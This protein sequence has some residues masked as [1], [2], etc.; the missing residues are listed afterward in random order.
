MKEGIP[1]KLVWVL[2]AVAVLGAAVFLFKGLAE[3][4]PTAVKPDD[5]K[6]SPQEFRM[7]K[8]QAEAAAKGKP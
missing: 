8:E 1:A 3:P 5:Y 4:D 6:M 7:K 2:I